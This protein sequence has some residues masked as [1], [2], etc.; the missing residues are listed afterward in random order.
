MVIGIQRLDTGEIA[1]GVPPRPPITPLAPCT[2][3]NK[4]TEEDGFTHQLNLSYKIDDNRMIYVTWST[5]F[6]PGGVNRRGDLAPFE[7][8][9]LTNYEFG[10]KT[11]TDGQPPALQRRRLLGRM[12]GLPILIHWRERADANSER[13]Q[14]DDQRHRVRHRVG[15]FGPLHAHRVGGVLEHGIHTQVG[16]SSRPRRNCRWCRTSKSV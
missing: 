15:G 11:T 8:D 10:W 14:C 7:S 2:N 3:I 9:F 16:L 13:R 12:G 1:C 6:R 5:G 4:S